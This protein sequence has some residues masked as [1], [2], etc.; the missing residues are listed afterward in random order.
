MNKH[1]RHSP[2][3]LF[4]ALGIGGCICVALFS[5]GVNGA[6][7]QET[8]TLTRFH[9]PVVMN[10]SM[11]M[12]LPT[13]NT[14]GYRLYSAHQDILS[15]IPFQFDE[16]DERGEMVFSETAAQ[17][18]F[19]FDENDEL[20]FMAKDTGDRIATELLPAMSDAAVEIEV[21]DPVTR[22]RGWAY[23]LYFP[24]SMPPSSPVTYARFDAEAN[25][26]RTLFYTVD[27]YPG[28]NFFTGLRI[29]P[30][31]GGTDEDILERIKLRVH[32]TFSMFLST[33]S[34]LFT[35]E[36][37]SVR[38]DGVKNGPV[39]AVRRARVALNLG[40]YFPDIP[41]GTAYTYYYFSSFT[42]PSI[43]S[44]PWLV[45]KAL[46]DF[47]FTVVNEF[48]G[49]AR[50]MT[51]RDATNPRDL[52]FSAPKNGAETITDTDHDW[53]VVGGKQGTYLQAFMIPEQWTDWG[54]VRG[55]VFRSEPPAAGYSLL[56]MTNVRKPGNYHMNMI[57]VILTRPYQTGDESP[58]LA[59]LRH[60]L[61]SEAK[62]L[63]RRAEEKRI[64]SVPQSS[65]TSAPHVGLP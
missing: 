33:W 46:Q 36:D 10:T 12:G 58:P 22:A 49:S 31:R 59:M 50:E 9:D 54:I 16:R 6:S 15:P 41:G 1:R 37:F 5:G 11:L 14:V 26:A 13:R 53:Y 62:T 21:T 2:S 52:A 61:H 25:Q 43:F 32:P 17:S 65:K 47:Q 51:Y 23:L 39:R 64:A 20:V 18:E 19:Q 44:A 3:A 7:A 34:P 55:A 38:I 40:R 42:T 29:A 8:K 56:N 4:Q 48:R 35:E 28:R 24:G 30:A 57:F 27:N 63:P 60:P 45:L